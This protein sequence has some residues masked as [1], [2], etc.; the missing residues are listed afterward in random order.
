MANPSNIF[1]GFP[2]FASFTG[3]AVSDG[4]YSDVFVTPKVDAT[5]AAATEIAANAGELW[6]NGFDDYLAI[7]YPF[8]ESRAPEVVRDELPDSVATTV[9]SIAT[10]TNTVRRFTATAY[11]ATT[12]DTALGYVQN[13]DLLLKN[14]AGTVTATVIDSSETRIGDFST[15]PATLTTAH[16]VNGT[17]FDLV[18]TQGA[19]DDASIDLHID[20]NKAMRG[21]PL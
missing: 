20:V 7:T 3:T 4:T 5:A 14:E 1:D 11:V 13:I 19:V 21:A 15:S 2:P 16:A 9:Y 18:W 17:A 8:F 10:S 12:D 6:S